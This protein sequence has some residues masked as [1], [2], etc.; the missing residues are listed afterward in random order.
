MSGGKFI[1]LAQWEEKIGKNFCTIRIR[2]ITQMWY[3]LVGH[4]RD[5]GQL[6]FSQLDIGID[7]Q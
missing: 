1:K 5:C 3:G 6:Q 7:G 2:N 4:P